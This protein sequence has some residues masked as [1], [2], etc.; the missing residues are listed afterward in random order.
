MDWLDLLAVQETLKS[1][2][3]HHSLKASILQC[4]AFFI[5]PFSHPYYWKTHS[6]D[7]TNLCGQSLPGI[8]VKT[9]P[10]SAFV[11]WKGL[12]EGWLQAG[13][14]GRDGFVYWKRQ[15]TVGRVTKKVL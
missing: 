1:L 5:V 10:S 8:K 12:H 14:A 6:L 13:L 4:P 15:N 7:Y 2:L 11:F 3:Q 9:Y